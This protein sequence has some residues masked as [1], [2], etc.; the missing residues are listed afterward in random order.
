MHDIQI[1][2]LCGGRSLPQCSASIVF[3]DLTKLRR[4]VVPCRNVVTGKIALGPSGVVDPVHNAMK[5]FKDYVEI[6]HL[7]CACLQ[8][9]FVKSKCVSCTSLAVVH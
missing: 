7:A 6:Q 4:A 1:V 2:S 5:M 3:V 8:S 9:V